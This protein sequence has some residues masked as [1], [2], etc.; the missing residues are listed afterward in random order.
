M[1]HTFPSMWLT[2]I[3]KVKLD[4]FDNLKILCILYILQFSLF[5]LYCSV[6]CG[7]SIIKFSGLS[8][9]YKYFL[10][11]LV[12]VVCRFPLKCP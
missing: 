4:C 3:D 10:L 8:A 9:V 6:L 5:A 2:I 11:E 12:F 7:L 1:D